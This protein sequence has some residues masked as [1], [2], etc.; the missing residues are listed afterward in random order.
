MTEVVSTRLPLHEKR[1]VQAV[2]AK[3]EGSVAELVRE[4][5]LGLIAQEV[6]QSL[7]ESRR[8]FRKGGG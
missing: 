7:D 8:E 4:A 2:A 6:S 3:R 1:M 5:V